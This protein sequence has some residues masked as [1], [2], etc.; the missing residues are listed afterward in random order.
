MA[1][2][3]DRSKEPALGK[4]LT[5]DDGVASDVRIVNRSEK[6]AGKGGRERISP[7]A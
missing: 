6:M 3:I 7:Q 2:K 4:K 5:L 1:D